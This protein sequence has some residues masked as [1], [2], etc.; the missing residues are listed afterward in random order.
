MKYWVQSV[1]ALKHIFSSNLKVL[2]TCL[3]PSSCAGNLSEENV[4]SLGGGGTSVGECNCCRV[5]G[6]CTKFG[7]H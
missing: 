6:G 3:P 5:G 2:K 7:I 1:G 4:E